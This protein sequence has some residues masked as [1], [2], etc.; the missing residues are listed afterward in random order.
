MVTKALPSPKQAAITPGWSAQ[1]LANRSSRRPALARKPVQYDFSPNALFRGG[2]N[3]SLNA[4]VGENGGPYDL[5]DYGQGFFD[6]ARAI[7]DAA[8]TMKIPVDVAIYPAAFAY[9]HGIELYLK[10]FLAEL[11][12]FTGIDVKPEKNRGIME[13]V[14]RIKDMLS[15]SNAKIADPEQVALVASIIKDFDQIDPTGQVFRYPED[16]KGNPHLTGLG[17]INVAVLEDGMATLHN[18]METWIYH[19]RTLQDYKNE[20]ADENRDD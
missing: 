11:T 2:E 10:C 6:G 16:I 13:Y 5:R 4:C 8:K 17:L 18:I 14:G 12:I 7:V 19:L 15:K 1:N 3:Y 20:W 9:R